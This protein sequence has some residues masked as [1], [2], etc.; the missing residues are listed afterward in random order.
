MSIQ[1]NHT[2]IYAGVAAHV[3][4]VIGDEVLWDWTHHTKGFITCRTALTKFAASAV[5]VAP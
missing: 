4:A 5:E 1:V 3:F 2:Y